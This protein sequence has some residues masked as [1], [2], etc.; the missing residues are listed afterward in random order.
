MI[1]QLDSYRTAGSPDNPSNLYAGETIESRRL[2]GNTLPKLNLR[3]TAHEALCNATLQLPKNFDDFNARAFIM[4]AR[5]LATQ[6]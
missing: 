4:N 6:I 5:E 3:E 1:I 2:F